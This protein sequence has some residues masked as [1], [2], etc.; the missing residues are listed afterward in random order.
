LM[1]LCALIVMVSI[2]LGH[3]A[4]Y[5]QFAFWADL[6]A[7]LEPFLNKSHLG[8][9][10]CVHLLA[11]AYLMNQLFKS[12]SYWLKQSMSGWIIKMGQQSLPIFLCGM[13]LSYIG[14]VALD[15]SGDDA[16]SVAMV[17]LAG[18]GLMLLLAQVLAWLDSK[19]W[20][21]PASR[22]HPNPSDPENLLLKLNKLAYDWG[23]QVL[24]LPFLIGLAV[25]PILLAQTEKAIGTRSADI[26]ANLSRHEEVQKV[27]AVVP[28]ADQPDT[29][30]ENQQRL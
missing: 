22:H 18:L 29:V 5:T 4:T 14:G 19:P 11:L 10:R 6:R 26:M 30:I 2:P 7:V 17:N 24:L 8:P 23:K 16:F 3:E 1:V 12:N 27:N 9:I 20:K 21:L 25:L 15:W 28:R 13:G